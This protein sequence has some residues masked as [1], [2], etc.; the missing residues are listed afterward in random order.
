MES[1]DRFERREP[2]GHT[3]GGQPV[4]VAVAWS[5]GKDAA[6]ALHRLREREDAEI[7]ELFTTA[8]ADGPTTMH[9]IPR[10]LIERQVE[11]LGVPVRFVDLPGGGGN[12]GYRA[13][14]DD[15]FA[16]YERRGIDRVVYGDL[17]L[18]DVRAYRESMLADRDLD[19]WW[20]LWGT[21]TADLAREFLAAGFEATVVCVDGDALDRSVVG[22]NYDE[23]F[24]DSLP[25]GVDPAG[26]NGEFHTFV[27]DGPPFA[28]PVPVTCGEGTTHEREV[29]GETVRLHYCDLVALDET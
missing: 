8:T 19:G 4:R 22:R 2:L 14:M 26:E 13:T 1:A 7:V 15:L 10:G 11:V 5:G 20:P 21:D 12:E 24:L 18:E 6:L 9:R 29:D 27:R 3:D 25:E 16:D 23:A 28:A 17:R